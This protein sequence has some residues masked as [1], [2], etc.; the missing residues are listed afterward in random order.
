MRN[1]IGLNIPGS[2]HH[3]INACVAG[4]NSPSQV[5]AVTPGII[6]GKQGANAVAKYGTYSSG[7]AFK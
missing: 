1:Q 3:C 2:F 7:G 4:L 6:T 5:F